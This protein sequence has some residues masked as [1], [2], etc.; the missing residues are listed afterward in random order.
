MGASETVFTVKTPG[1]TSRPLLYALNPWNY[2]KYFAAGTGPLTMPAGGCE[3]VGFLRS[4]MSNRTA[5]DVQLSF[6]SLHAGSDL[7]TM[8]ADSLNLNREQVGRKWNF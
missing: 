1:I 2:A 6:L 7:G 3:A 8:F 4:G 5:P